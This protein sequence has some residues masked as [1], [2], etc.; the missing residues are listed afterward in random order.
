MLWVRHCV[1]HGFRH[2]NFR[3]RRGPLRQA[4]Y[5]EKSAKSEEGWSSVNEENWTVLDH[6]LISGP[7][8]HRIE[9]T[10]TDAAADLHGR[11]APLWVAAG[12]RVTSPPTSTLEERGQ[13][14]QN[15]GMFVT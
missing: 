8:V 10:C 6:A 13:I 4:S 2:L 14:W 11:H 1:A 3:F 5:R 9:D 12:V 7:W 15:H